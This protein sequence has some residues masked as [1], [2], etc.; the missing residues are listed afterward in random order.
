MTAPCVGCHDRDG[1][2]R[3]QLPRTP[4]LCTRCYRDAKAELRD[5][6]LVRRRW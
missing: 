2:A 1:I 6:S 4:I 3:S 5:R